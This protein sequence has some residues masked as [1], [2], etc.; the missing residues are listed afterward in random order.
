M[1]SGRCRSLIAHPTNLTLGGGQGDWFNAP[2]WGYDTEQNPLALVNGIPQQTISNPFPS[3][4]N[5]LLPAKGNTYGR[6]YGLGEGTITW[7]NPQFKRAVNDR[8]NVTFSRQIWNQ[9]VAEATYL[10]NLGRDW[11]YFGRDVNAWDPRIGYN[12]PAANKSAMAANVANPFY[13]YLTAA[14]YP[15]PTRNNKNIATYQLLRPYPQYGALW[16]LYQSNQRDRYHALQLKAQRP[17]RNGYNFIV[18]YNYR[19]EKQEG[20]YDELDQFLGK[21]TWLEG[22]PQIA[23]GSGQAAPRHS[24][25]IAGSYELPFGKGRAYGA[26]MPAALDYV[27]GGWQLI[28]AWYF[29]SGPILVFGPMVATGN[30]HLDDPT[31]AKWFDTSKFSVLP[32]Y[33]QRTNPRTYLDVRGPIYWDIQASVGKTFAVGDKFKTQMKLTAYNLT[34]R[35][36]RANPITDVSLTTFG[37]ARRQATGMTG[38]QLEFSLKILF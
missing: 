13:N 8:I 24:M 30:P 35:L 11:S 6:Y 26:S 29:N 4:S 31:P 12:L 37:T 21:L 28:G 7:I 22:G 10:A 20:Y 9:I 23:M 27:F 17:F 2:Y 25:S 15:G 1:S 3:S 14:K 18:G 38:R 36:N 5:P 34:N 16:V 33:T 19:R 32:A